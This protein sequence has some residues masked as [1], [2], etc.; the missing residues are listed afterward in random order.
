MNTRAFLLVTLLDVTLLYGCSQA[1]K[2]ENEG[3]NTLRIGDLS[4]KPIVYESVSEID[5]TNST[6]L[7]NYRAY[8]ADD[9]N[10]LY[11]G[12]ALRRLAALELEESETVHGQVTEQKTDAGEQALK[13]SIQ[14]YKDYLQ[15]YPDKKDNDAVL[16]QMAKAYAIFGDTEK[17]LLTLDEIIMRYPE[18]EYFDEVQF[19]RGEILFVFGDYSSAELAYASI[20]RKAASTQYLDNA[21]YKLAWSQ[22]KQAKY[23][24]SLE[25]C[26]AL[27]DKKQAQGH[28][29]ESSIS[30]STLKSDKDFINDVLRV[31]SLALSYTEGTKTIQRILAGGPGRKYEPLLYRRLGE[32]Y[33]KTDRIVDAANVYLDY[34]R[35]HPDTLMA[36][37]FHALAIESYASGDFTELLLATKANYV[38]EFGVGSVFWSKHD[39]VS[40]QAVTVALKANILDLAKYYHAIALKTKKS[41][42]FINA[43]TWYEKY[44][45]SFPQDTD[46]P[47]MNFLLAETEYDAGS[48]NKAL[49]EYV[50]TAYNYSTH[51]KS[52]ESGYAAVLTYKLLIEKANKEANL[53]VKAELEADALTNA[54]RFSNQFKDSKYAP[55]VIANTAEILYQ[56]KDYQG[57]MEFSRNNAQLQTLDD[58]SYF[59]ATWL[60]YAHSLF[61]LKEYA[62]A[63]HAY[64]TVL[65]LIRNTDPLYKAVSEKLAASI[66]M[67][68]QQQR[69]NR[70]YELA[71]YHF[72]RV[73]Q[74][75]PTTTIFATA[76]YDAAAM[77][78]QLENWS[79]AIS[80]LEAFRK[81]FPKN[82]KYM[83]GVSEKLALAYT[84]TG[85]SGK[86]ADEIYHL[87]VTS[88]DIAERRKLTW[89]A[90]EAY[91]KA[92]LFSKSNEIYIAYISKYPEPF[93]QNIEAHQ[94]VIDYYRENKIYASL[95]KWQKITV[96]AEKRGKGNRT[97]RTR[98]IAASA[99]IELAD[100]LVAEYK[101]TK[102]TVPLKKS[103]KLKKKYME[104]ALKSYS[105]L[106]NYE[107][108]E[109]TTESTYHVADIYA[110][111][112][113]ALLSSQRPKNLNEEE[114]EEYD[115]LLE[116]QAYPFEEKSIQIHSANAK[117]TSTGLYDD[118][119]KKSIEALSIL[120]PIRYAK[121]E[122]IETYVA[123]SI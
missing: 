85:Q 113:R 84:Q 122:R 117:R 103:L 28:L 50:N 116:E 59:R 114:L 104:K 112:A 18:T 81:Q 115:I 68:G 24:S 44:I 83:R 26:I 42:D 79:G 22:F 121:S 31:A 15:L 82:S 19:R 107:I 123:N 76:Q 74:R 86:A 41:G 91:Q 67:Q 89:Q 1:V 9:E 38:Q 11:H 12:E 90:A 100:L 95:S 51:T 48:Y 20:V 93:A 37:E 49:N 110:H 33:I 23:I 96:D 53:Q 65:P 72:L 43:S 35:L 101:K 55:A 70:Q 47:L 71:C 45:R 75:V 16:Y 62:T 13:Y 7:E 111:F 80:I 32:H 5:P 2:A 99:A 56:N 52:A 87:S 102:L 6:A 73:G 40:K 54:I 46:T 109:I 69:E 78:I 105:D 77:Q 39:T 120:E 29:V 94:R 36:A 61:E 34:A 14:H 88:A 27:L 64:D 97:D 30:T 3:L 98:F 92:G 63:E 66:Y 108:A 21:Q 60:V 57:A 17:A 58:K 106:M 8:L 4:K 25:N 119:V 10:V 118:W